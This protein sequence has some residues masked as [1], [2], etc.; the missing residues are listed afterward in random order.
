MAKATLMINRYLKQAF[1][2]ATRACLAIYI[3]T[4]AVSAIAEA[5]LSSY[6]AVYATRLGGASIEI[7][8]TLH[9][10]NNQYELNLSASAMLVGFKET[11]VFEVSD[12]HIKPLNYI[13]Q[14]TGLNR[15]KSNNDFNW[16][17]GTVSSFYKDNWY[18]LDIQPGV[19]DRISWHEQMRLS[20]LSGSP[21]DNQQFNII[22]GKRIKTY[23]IEYVGEETLNTALGTLNA[24]HYTRT[25][26]NSEQEF[27]IWLAKDWD[28]LLLK[29]VQMDAY[30]ETSEV[31]L[32]SARLD[33][34]VVTGLPQ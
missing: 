22:S 9:T 16:P 1:Y 17:E 32:K 20:L 26:S 13:Y 21:P 27:H 4:F 24:L 6:E 5:P 29:I 7:T 2:S 18:Q 23:Q 15:R 19:Y 30:N 25:R 11:S 34:Q 31:S 14:G 33:G 28:Y 12:Q 8:R 10:T 3:S